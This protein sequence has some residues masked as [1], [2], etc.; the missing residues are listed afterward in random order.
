MLMEVNYVQQM[1]QELSRLIG[2]E[3]DDWPDIYDSLKVIDVEAK[4]CLQRAGKAVTHH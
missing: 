3:I 2:M 4:Y 1:Q